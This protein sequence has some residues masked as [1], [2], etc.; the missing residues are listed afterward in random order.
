MSDAVEIA[1][2]TSIG[3]TLV[4]LVGCYISYLNRGKID[5]VEKATNGMKQELV[6][7]AKRE[8]HSEGRKAEREGQ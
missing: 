3:P 5:R 4:G 7:A 8:G 1:I 2:I 6:A